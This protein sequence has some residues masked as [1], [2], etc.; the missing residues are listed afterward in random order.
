[1]KLPIERD[2]FTLVVAEQ[3]AGTVKFPDGKIRRFSSVS[4]V[5]YESAGIYETYEKIPGELVFTVEKA[6]QEILIPLRQVAAVEFGATL[7]KDGEGRDR[8]IT[9]NVT[10]LNGTQEVFACDHPHFVDINWA[11]SVAT[12]RYL[13]RDLLG[14]RIT[15]DRQ[16]Q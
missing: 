12:I 5:R 2:V 7:E 4:G 11:D 3:Q 14:V 9:V 15:F 8:V 6:D 16:V 13:N 10:S 1:M